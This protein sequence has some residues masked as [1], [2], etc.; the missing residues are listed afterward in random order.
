MVLQITEGTANA[1]ATTDN[2]TTTT[3]DKK[4][5][6]DAGVVFSYDKKLV[7]HY[8]NYYFLQGLMSKVG[9]LE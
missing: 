5:K 9:N 4:V 1:T 6:W 3:P 8:L 2:N 7:F